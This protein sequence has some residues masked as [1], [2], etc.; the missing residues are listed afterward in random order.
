MKFTRSVGRRAI[1]LLF[2]QAFNDIFLSMHTLCK[3]G[4]DLFRPSGQ[5]GKLD[6]VD[7]GKLCDSIKEEGGGFA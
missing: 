1:F 5:T 3:Q 7:Q 2:S 4:S 6:P